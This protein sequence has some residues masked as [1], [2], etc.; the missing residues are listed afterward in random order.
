MMLI[1]LGE[2]IK[3]KRL[4]KFI[5]LQDSQGPSPK[6]VYSNNFWAR[7]HFSVDVCKLGKKLKKYAFI[8]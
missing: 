5:K 3:L 8:Q 7:K 4:R 1:R 6:F 2:L